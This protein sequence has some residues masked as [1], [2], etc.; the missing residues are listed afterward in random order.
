M[1]TGKNKTVEKQRRVEKKT[2]QQHKT[3]RFEVVFFCAVDSEID[4]K[5]ILF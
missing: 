4:A 2:Q 1:H 3:N 5:I